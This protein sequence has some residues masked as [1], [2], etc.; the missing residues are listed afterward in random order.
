MAERL[1]AAERDLRVFQKELQDLKRSLT[2]PSP[3]QQTVEACSKLSS[4]SRLGTDGN[5]RSE[6]R[7]SSAKRRRRQSGWPSLQVSDDG[8]VS[9]DEDEDQDEDEESSSA[10]PSFKRRAGDKTH[11]G[12]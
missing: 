11:S 10:A 7:G 1:K 5:Q 4:P 8:C 12:G 9:L 3:K 6:I 2:K